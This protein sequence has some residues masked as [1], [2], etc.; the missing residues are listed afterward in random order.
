M[1]NIFPFDSCY[2][3]HTK[4]YESNGYVRVFHFVFGEWNQ[5]GDD[6]FGY[7]SY[8]NLGQFLSLSADGGIL[9]S[10]D[11]NGGVVRVFKL[12][13]NITLDCKD[14]PLIFK[15]TNKND[16]SIKKTCAWVG[17]AYAKSR[18][19]LTGVSETC[20]AT[21]NTCS[22][23]KDSPLMV[24]VKFGKKKK[25]KWRYCAWAAKKSSQRCAI[26][27]IAETCKLTCGTCSP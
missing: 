4:G 3:A 8:S 15:T 1:I 17:E 14:S 25:R 2:S 16:Q 11:R 7:G 26:K 23:C 20:P 12:D 22:S 27:E 13:S 9:A 24:K 10:S 19:T 21:C 5:I 18:C 6:I